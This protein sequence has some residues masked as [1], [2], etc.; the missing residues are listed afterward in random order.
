V[1]LKGLGIIDS[2][3]SGMGSKFILQRGHG[4]LVSSFCLILGITL[5]A[6]SLGWSQEDQRLAP[7]EVEA[8]SVL[9]PGP[10]PAVSEGKIYSGKKT[11][12]TPLPE[13]LPDITINNYRQALTHTPGLLVS[14]V[15]NESWTSLNFRGLGDPH[16][17]YN[18]LL[19]QDGRPITTDMY[20]YP[21]GYYHPNI[22]FV[23]RIEFVRGGA[24]LMYGPQPG[25][26][27][28]YITREPNPN[29]AF[30]A[31]S[32]HVFGSW[33][34]YS[35]YNEV[36]GSSGRHSYLGQ[37]H[38]RQSDG[39]RTQNSDY[40]ILQG[41][42]KYRL[43]ISERSRVRVDLDAHDGDHGEPGG[44]AKTPAAGLIGIDQDRFATTLP[45]DRFR[46]ER[47]SAALGWDLKLSERAQIKT[48]VWGGE[49][50]RYS[51]RQAIS[52]SAFGRIANGTTN[53]IQEQ[54]F[55]FYGG[56]TRYSQD[57]STGESL[58][59]LSAGVMSFNVDS[60]FRQSLGATPT[61][62][63]GELR[64]SISRTTRAVSVFAENR[65]DLGDFGITPGVRVENINQKVAETL[66]VDA[67]VPLR[68]ASDSVTVPL[69]GLG[70]D[71]QLSQD[72]QLYAN[73]SQ[74]YKPV[75]FQ[76]AVPLGTG[77]TISED[78][79][80]AEIISAEIGSRGTLAS[81]LLYDVSLFHI[82]YSN[83][84]G[85]I[86]TSATN[87]QNVGRA[88][89]QG[90]DVSLNWGLSDELDARLGT[91]LS[92][93]GQIRLH[94]NASVMKAE[95]ID[96][97][98]TGKRPQYAPEALVRAGV[99]W[100]K[101]DRAKLALLST[102]ITKHYANDNNTS[103][104]EIPAYN[105]WDFSGEW[106]FWKPS[107][108]TSAGLVFGVSNL[109]DRKYHSRVRSNGIEPAAPRNWYAGLNVSF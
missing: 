50:V 57:W 75:T 84:F 104:F 62:D 56:Q 106:N 77:E 96:G 51:R 18:I 11:T 90:V 64:R 14:E 80:P 67:T 10:M 94:T 102:W 4:M 86:T 31:R 42:L 105:V 16:E 22:D 63:D 25:G 54:T 76:D 100:S 108:W 59:T 8:D 73:V 27:L 109:F 93:L 68:Q 20:G 74:A 95:F 107:Q 45:N 60:P 53:T 97:P 103:D 61:S 40:Q 24:A 3:D 26:A 55:H 29:G 33:N 21:A 5:L 66:N 52:G 71:Y 37:F 39:Y 12:V 58:H 87:F 44:L 89:H 99:T 36:S 83:Q 23:E 69:F 34:L 72:D 65:F 82:D 13:V 15:A 30:F 9:L 78:I 28:N 35:T 85:K 47:Q 6:P 19:L 43:Q 79:K 88:Q 41:A 70:A 48:D 101:D 91:D 92:S 38:L 17:T 46:L 98:A 1:L 2:L 49:L 7:I 81:S 32:K